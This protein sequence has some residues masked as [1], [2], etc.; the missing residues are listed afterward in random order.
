MV[1]ICERI[2]SCELGAL[3]KTFRCCLPS[4]ALLSRVSCTEVITPC[5]HF[6]VLCEKYADCL[7]RGKFLLLLLLRSC[8]TRLNKR[9]SNNPKV[10][11]K[12]NLLQDISE[13]D[14]NVDRGLLQHGGRRSNS[15]SVSDASRGG[16]RRREPRGDHQQNNSPVP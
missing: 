15:F 13:N 9:S 5:R 3:S 11:N 14:W 1:S 2:T 10:G 6:S 7:L 8:H 16:R 4:D 12:K